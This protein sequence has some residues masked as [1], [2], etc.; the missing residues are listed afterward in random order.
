MR[1]LVGFALAI[2]IIATSVQPV[3]AQFSYAEFP[4]FW[5]TTDSSA[6]D[7]QRMLDGALY[8][9]EESEG[10]NG[11]RS[12]RLGTSDPV[13]ADITLQPTNLFFTDRYDA[14]HRAIDAYD[15]LFLSPLKTGPP[16]F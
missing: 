8:L 12:Q 7:V 10:P 3:Q 4:I 11:R 2:L 16:S 15:G 6:A 1:K 14:S 13:M 5:L 9:S